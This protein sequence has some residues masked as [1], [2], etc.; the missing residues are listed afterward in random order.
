MMS[1]PVIL[2]I[3]LLMSGVLCCAASTLITL[4]RIGVLSQNLRSEQLAQESTEQHLIESRADYEIQT[5]TVLDLRDQLMAAKAALQG[6]RDS[7]KAR[8]V[9]REQA[10]QTAAVP[11]A[12]VVIG[13][14]ELIDQ[15]TQ[16]TM[17]C[18][19][20]EEQLRAERGLNDEMAQTLSQRQ[21]ELAETQQVLEL[22]RTVMRQASTKPPAAP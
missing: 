20:L 6:V 2:P 12:P 13:D 7:L 17:Q 9:E 11:P 1:G 18:H 14:P 5:R 22:Q 10:R 16:R 15:L 19:M 21:K 3:V 8:E 4:P